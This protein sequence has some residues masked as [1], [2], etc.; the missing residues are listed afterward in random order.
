MRSTFV[1]HKAN[2]YRPYLVRR[3]GLLV[4][5][6]I[7]AVLQLGYNYSQTGQVLG[8]VSSTNAD[9]L[10]INTNNERTKQNLPKLRMSP[11]LSRAATMKAQDMYAK[12]YWAHDAPDGTQPWHWF[13]AVGYDYSAAG[14]N[15]AKNFSNSQA[16][17]TAWMNSPKHRENILNNQ[18][19]EVGF[20][21][22]QGTLNDTP[23]TIVVALYGAPSTSAVAGATTALAAATQT[24]SPAQAPISR[25]GIALQSLT[26]AA[27]ASLVILMMALII[28]LIAHAYRNKLPSQLRRTWYRHHGVIKASSIAILMLLTVWLYSNGQI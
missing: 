22:A 3:Y 1:P 25:L 19:A 5:A 13:Q 6:A 12:Q 26:P 23:T 8:Q 27:V 4:V 14:E 2:Q 18:Y 24:G 15:L 21:V 10:L 11:Q 9:E 17:L 7:V 16:T 28:A 20:A